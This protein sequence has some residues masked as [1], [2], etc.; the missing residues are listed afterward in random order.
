MKKN[1]FIPSSYKILSGKWFYKQIPSVQKLNSVIRWD[2][3]LS[4]C[5]EI[6]DIYT[7]N[8]KKKGMNFGG[9]KPFIHMLLYLENMKDKKEI[10]QIKRTLTLM[11]TSIELLN[12]YIVHLKVI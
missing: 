9:N 8:A 12:S 2:S 5:S 11:S 6:L 1:Y 3:V 10:I 4:F 7:S